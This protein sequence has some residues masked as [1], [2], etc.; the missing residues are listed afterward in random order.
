MNAI[1]SNL[2]LLAIVIASAFLTVSCGETENRKTVKNLEKCFGNIKTIKDAEVLSQ[3][4]AIEIAQCML[5][6]LQ[7]VKD[8]VDKM[9]REEAGIF[10]DQLEVETNKSEYSEIIKE[11]DY[12]KVKQ[13]AALGRENNSSKPVSSN[14]DWDKIL[15][16]YENYIDEYLKFLKKANQGDMSAMLE[17][18]E[19][20]E[21]AED[22]DRQLTDADDQLTNR[23]LS[24]FAKIQN[25][26]TE[27]MLEM[28]YSE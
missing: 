6:H 1:K 9:S 5:P 27:A 16:D 22:L 2:K 7:S 24:R 19:L 12:R 14:R 20:L 4:E 8:K 13:L 28:Y 21:K 18:N 23:Q 11:L 17:Y 25:K 26:M 10:L 3:E 15:D